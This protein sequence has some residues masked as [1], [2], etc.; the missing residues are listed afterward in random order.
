ML[1]Q[2]SLNK[3]KQMAGEKKGKRRGYI[4]GSRG[5]YS[6]TPDKLLTQCIEHSKLAHTCVQELNRDIMFGNWMFS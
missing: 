3:I 6:K 2:I 4:K 5:T 1:K